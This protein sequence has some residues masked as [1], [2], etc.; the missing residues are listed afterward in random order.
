MAGISSRKEESFSCVT[1][2]MYL[3]WEA[4]QAQSVLASP[5][6]PPASMKRPQV[7]TATQLLPPWTPHP[8]IFTSRQ[9]NSRPH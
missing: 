7:L 9:L 8:S 5:Q 6:L 4:V 2:F 1:D 3:P